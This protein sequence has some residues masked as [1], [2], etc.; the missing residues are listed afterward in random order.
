[1]LEETRHYFAYREDKAADSALNRFRR[2]FLDPSGVSGA[3]TH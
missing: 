1:V 2:S 3:S